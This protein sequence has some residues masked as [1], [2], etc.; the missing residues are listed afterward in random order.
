MNDITSEAPLT[1]A[2]EESKPKFKIRVTSSVQ[3]KGLKVSYGARPSAPRGVS[4]SQ[5]LKTK[6]LCC[7]NCHAEIADPTMK[8]C[9]WCGM[10]LPA[11]ER[12]EKKEEAAQ[13]TASAANVGAACGGNEDE[14]SAAAQ[15]KE[16][17]KSDPANVILNGIWVVKVIL[18]LILPLTFGIIAASHGISFWLGL[19]SGIFAN[20]ILRIYFIGDL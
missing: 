15:G 16:Q 4:H 13:S 11:V 18:S 17:G 20:F 2:D 7:P 9:A 6:G 14:I 19:V 3:R 12:R 8:F 10:T 5:A 1:T